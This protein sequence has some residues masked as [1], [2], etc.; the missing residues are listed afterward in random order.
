MRGPW[1]NEFVI[2]TTSDLTCPKALGSSSTPGRRCRLFSTVA[3]TG[4]SLNPGH[5]DSVERPPGAAIFCGVVNAGCLGQ[6]SVMPPVESTPNLVH[7][8]MKECSCARAFLALFP[9]PLPLPFFFTSRKE[10]G[11]S[12]R[13]RREAHLT[14]TFR[15]LGVY[16]VACSLD[17]CCSSFCADLMQNLVE[18]HCRY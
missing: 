15:L 9:L 7:W 5:S 18:T 16:G 12:S 10:G 1:L 4:A 13:P 8:M 6:V 2:A 11:C 3:G 17:R 14:P